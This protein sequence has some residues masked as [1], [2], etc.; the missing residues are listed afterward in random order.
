MKQTRNRSAMRRAQAGGRSAHPFV[1]IDAPVG[2]W[3][4]RD[5][6]DNVP[7]TD[8]LEFDNWW[9]D[10][11]E[12]RTRP[13]YSIF[14]CTSDVVS[15]SDL[16]SNGGFETP[17]VGADVFDDWIDSVID[18]GE[19]QEAEYKNS[20]S[21][22]CALIEIETPGT[23]VTSQTVT[24]L[25]AETWYK[26]TFYD[27]SYSN[28]NPDNTSSIRYLVFDST[29]VE[30]IVN[31]TNTGHYTGGFATPA[32]EKTEVVFQTPALC[33]S[34]MISFGLGS[35]RNVYYLVD[36]VSMYEIR[37]SHRR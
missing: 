15:G 19:V 37:L 7:P 36:D 18:S 6:E 22:A 34:V 27:T 13:G 3:N 16:I 28:V 20:G 25:T 29:N 4:T 2:G 1:R 8:A 31:W 32:Y 35:T 11:G 24:G 30:Y 14:K 26:L 9:A 23:A 17:G 21:K 33:T 5:S 10:I 12:V